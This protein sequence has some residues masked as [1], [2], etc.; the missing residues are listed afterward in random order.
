MKKFSH[1]YVEKEVLPN[2]I[3]Q[4]IL[5]KFPK[6][7]VVLIDR[8]SEVFNRPNQN[9]L[10]QK[11]RQNLILA[12]KDMILYTKVLSFVKTLKILIFTIHQIYLIVSMIV[13]IAIYRVCT[14]QDILLF[15]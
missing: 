4:N 2:P 12:Q 1:I 6:S 7:K 8:Y 15:L 13:I 11:E 14:P 10:I 5:K 3:T 9:Y